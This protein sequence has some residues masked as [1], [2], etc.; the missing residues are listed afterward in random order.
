MKLSIQHQESYSRGEL[1]LRTLFGFIYIMI[2]HFFV[3]L[4]VAIGAMFVNLISFWAILIMGKFPQGMWNYLYNLMRWTLRLNARLD[5]LADGYPAIGLG[6]QD[7]KTKL[8]MAYPESSS[9]G[10]LL[11][12]T[13]FGFIY[14]YIPHFF[15]LIFLQ[16]GGVFVKL[17]A[18]WVVLITGKYPK[19]MHDYMVGVLRWNMRVTAYMWNL[20]DTY[21]PF[22]MKEVESGTGALDSNV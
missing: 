9:R 16:L 4:F 7:D 13:F 2:P 1:L 17:I 3:L 20:T 11:L 5:N 12:R 18:F 22:S 19:G 8:E 15:C 14:V 6:G 10:L 21:P